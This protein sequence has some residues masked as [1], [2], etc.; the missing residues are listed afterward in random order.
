MTGDGAND[1]SAIKE[2]NIGLSFSQTEAS[3][4]APFSSFK[5]SIDCVQKVIC[6]GKSNIQ[7]NIEIFR[8]LIIT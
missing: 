2:A 5:T 8:Y 4:S 3:L 1:C 7:S 6:E